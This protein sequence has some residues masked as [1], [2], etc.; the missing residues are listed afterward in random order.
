MFV[1]G[2]GGDW[3]PPAAAWAMSALKAH[4][5]VGGIG[6]NSGWK[7]QEVLECPGGEGR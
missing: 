7:M 4:V 5:W 6:K 1:E 3:T 2:V